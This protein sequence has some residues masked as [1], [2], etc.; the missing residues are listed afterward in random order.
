MLRAGANELVVDAWMNRTPRQGRQYDHRTAKERAEQ[1]R[2]MY[3]EKGSEPNDFLGRRVRELRS[4]NVSE[5]DIQSIIDN[6]LSILH[7]TPYGTCSRELY[8]SPCDKTLVCI[9][10]FGTSDA[11]RSFQVDVTDQD[12][13]RNIEQLRASHQRMLGVLM[14][15]YHAL[16]ERLEAELDHSEPLDQHIEFLLDVVRSCDQVLQH[17]RDTQA[18]DSRNI[19]IKV[20]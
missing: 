16:G 19:D 3:L 17:Y 10:G 18:P 2:W 14:P 15:N 20:I 4:S 1:H 7:V 13:R 5:E 9:R 12:A 8:T 6:K 11:C